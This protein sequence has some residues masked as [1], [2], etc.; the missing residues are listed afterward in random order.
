MADENTKIPDFD[1]IKQANVYGV[2]YWSARE[3]MPLLGY[4]KSWQNFETALNK[5][6]IACEENGQVV[7]DHFNA[8]TKMVLL[9]SGAEREVKDYALS[10][11]ACY[12]VAMNGN[13]RKPEIAAAQNYFAVSTRSHEM[14]QIRKA[15]EERLETRLKVSESYKQLAKAAQVAGVHSES[16]GIFIDAGYLGLHRHTLQELKE[17][18]GIAEEE[19]YLDRIE[20][21][22]LS[23]IDFKN[24][25]TE[26]KLSRD[27]VNGLNEAAQTH[28][29]VGDQV[30][31]AIE[32][33][34]APMPEDLPSA[35]SIRALVE[36]RRRGKKKREKHL[37]SPDKPESPEQG[38][39]F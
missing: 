32:A 19:D 12:L 31:K 17:R 7:E 25:Q 4:G 14:H 20:R 2:E 39:L 10:R 22:E 8:S 35:A 5:A 6:M 27:Q 24:T 18:K 30:R 33:I 34:Q 9:G 37:P 16:F 28:Y 15:Q 23:A 26:E 21:Q 36:E 13:P 1:S 38:T 3:L 29:F 11:L